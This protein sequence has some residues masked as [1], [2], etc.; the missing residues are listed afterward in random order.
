MWAYT[1]C[2]EAE[3]YLFYLCVTKGKNY[4]II[5]SANMVVDDSIFIEQTIKEKKIKFSAL[6]LKFNT[7]D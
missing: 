1:S 4:Y 3:K 5:Q 6:F 7:T 2:I